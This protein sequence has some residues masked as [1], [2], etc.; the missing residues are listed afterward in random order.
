MLS[1]ARTLL[2]PDSATYYIM[3]KLGLR[4]DQA[5]MVIQDLEDNQIE[6]NEISREKLLEYA[7]GSI[8]FLIYEGCFPPDEQPGD[9]W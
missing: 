8:E 9:L 4:L 3:R 5:Q 6:P 1:R 2:H 7:H